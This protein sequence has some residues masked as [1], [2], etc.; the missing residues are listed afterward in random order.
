MKVKLAYGKEGLEVDLPGDRIT[1]IEPHYIPGL[2]DEQAAIRE[3]LASPIG[4]P[5]LGTWCALTR[6]WP[7]PSPM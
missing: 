2:A 4:C 1:I 6:R 3:A 5:R 7:S